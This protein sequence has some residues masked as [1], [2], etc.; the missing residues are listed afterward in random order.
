MVESSAEFERLTYSERETYLEHLRGHRNALILIGS[1][2]DKSDTY[3]QNH[4]S[5]NSDDVRKGR[6]SGDNRVVSL[7]TMT[8]LSQTLFN[9]IS[10]PL[11][12]TLQS[13]VQWI[14]P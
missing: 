2:C 5:N 3:D 11:L 6:D 10:I 1:F 4:D 12:S 14:T 13:F 7:R 9:S 8:T